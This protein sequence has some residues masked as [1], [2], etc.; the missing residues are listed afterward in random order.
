VCSTQLLWVS[1]KYEVPFSFTI[2]KQLLRHQL[3]A[4]PLVLACTSYWVY[5][6]YYLY[7]TTP[8]GHPQTKNHRLWTGDLRSQFKPATLP[9]QT[10]LTCPIARTEWEAFITQTFLIVFCC[11]F[12]RSLRLPNLNPLNCIFLRVLIQEPNVQLQGQHE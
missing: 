3:Q 12:N 5:V 9:F 1:F 6:K 7:S 2:N 4:L 10:S 11:N 8:S